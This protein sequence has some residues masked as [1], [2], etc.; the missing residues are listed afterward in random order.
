[1]LLVALYGYE[2]LKLSCIEFPIR[3]LKSCDSTGKKIKFNALLKEKINFKKHD[4]LFW[5]YST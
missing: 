2:R 3:P 1:M 5:I 4:L